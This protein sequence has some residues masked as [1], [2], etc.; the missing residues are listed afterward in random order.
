MGGGAPQAITALDG[1]FL[2]AAWID[3]DSLAFA[4]TQSQGIMR[5]RAAGGEPV[6]ITT[7]DTGAG[8]FVHAYPS[9]A[10]GGRFLVFTVGTNSQGG[11]QGIASVVPI[12]LSSMQV[13]G[14]PVTAQAG[15]DSNVT[16]NF[17]VAA[18][19]RRRR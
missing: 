18:T 6:R 17:A 8:Q 7:A 2:G 19:R 9:V 3:N 5:V 11:L 14:D 13:N 4:T 10:P 12:D 1:A 16:G 15:I